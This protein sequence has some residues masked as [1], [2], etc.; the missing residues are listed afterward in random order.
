MYTML[1]DTPQNI[2][3]GEVWVH[4]N[5]ECQ[6]GLEKLQ[7]RDIFIPLFSALDSRNKKLKLSHSRI[8]STN[9]VCPYHARLRAAPAAM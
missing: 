9:V 3:E 7:E 6:L 2:P 4:K 8:H 5:N 1:T